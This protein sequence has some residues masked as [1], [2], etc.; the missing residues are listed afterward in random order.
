VEKESIIADEHQDIETLYSYGYQ[1]LN[2]RQFKRSA[3]VFL[4][5]LHRD[6]D[7]VRVLVGLGVSLRK[8]GQY[9]NACV[10]FREAMKIEPSDPRGPYQLGIT[11]ILLGKR[12]AGRRLLMAT[13]AICTR[14]ADRW[15]SLRKAI[16]G[17][18]N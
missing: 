18:V 16:V 13:L 17:I 12:K 5:L 15:S 3:N 4:L 14:D 8:L 6:P 2:A 11:L 1:C 7:R 9:E 10:A